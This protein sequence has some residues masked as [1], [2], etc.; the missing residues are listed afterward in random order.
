MNYNLE[1]EDLATVGIQRVKERYIGRQI[2]WPDDHKL[3]KYL[4]L[5]L[6]SKYLGSYW[7]RF[8]GLQI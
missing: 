3:R 6:D 2:N 4:S 7:T 8:N 1:I 5:N